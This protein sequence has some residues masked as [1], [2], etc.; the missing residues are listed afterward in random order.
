MPCGHVSVGR[1]HNISLHSKPPEMSQIASC[2][3]AVHRLFAISFL[4]NVHLLSV[5][6][7]VLFIMLIYINE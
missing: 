6:H 4:L 2:L 1:C 7:T 3:H 5:T